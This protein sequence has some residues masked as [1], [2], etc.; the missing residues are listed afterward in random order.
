MR[1]VSKTCLHQQ[2]VSA[3]FFYSVLRGPIRAFFFVY[4]GFAL[5]WAGT[6]GVGTG[7]FMLG[8]APAGT[9]EVTIWGN[10]LRRVG[11]LY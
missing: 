4:S 8:H 9:F 7:M 5:S 1:M 3:G 11:S 10:L 6:A 2:G